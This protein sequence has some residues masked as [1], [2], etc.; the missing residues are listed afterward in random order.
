M[1]D[2]VLTSR[3]GILLLSSHNRVNADLF[4]NTVSLSETSRFRQVRVVRD[5]GMFDR[6]EAPQYYVMREAPHS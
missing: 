6:R 5:Y 1:F 3:D 4:A 2:A